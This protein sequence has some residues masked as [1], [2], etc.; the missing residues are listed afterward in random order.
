MKPL[1]HPQMVNGNFEDPVLFVDFLFERRALMFD[2]GDISALPAKKILRLSHVFISHTHM[3]HFIGFDHLLRICLGRDR[4]LTLFG[5]PGFIDQVEHK[6]NAYTWNLLQN[7]NNNFSIITNE[8]HETGSLHQAKFCC[9]DRFRRQD[10]GTE[11]TSNGVIVDETGFRVKAV[12]LD[13]KIPCLAFALEEAF[14]INVW[15]NRLDSLALPTGKWLNDLKDAIR[16]GKP[17]DTPVSIDWQDQQGKHSEQHLLG[18]L[19]DKIISI[20]P[21]QKISY[22]VDVAYSERNRKHIVALGQGVDLFYI[23]SVFLDADKDRATRTAHLTARQ[24]GKLAREAGA[25]KLI[26]IHFS[27]RYSDCEQALVDEAQNA[28]AEY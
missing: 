27:P 10:L 15:K 6:L 23:E 5:P 12:T 3:D 8:V 26:P 2:L 22:V 13:H 14:H 1:F 18:E 4:N 28:F 9:Q 11:Q 24:A 21:G 20:T 19:R 17:D 25:R 7:Y 16:L